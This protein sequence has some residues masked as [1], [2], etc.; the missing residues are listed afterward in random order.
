[1]LPCSM[2]KKNTWLSMPVVL[3]VSSIVIKS[4]KTR[5]V[6]IVRKEEKSAHVARSLWSRV[7]S[8][9]SISLLASLKMEIVNP[10]HIFTVTPTG[11][12]F[13]CATAVCCTL[14][15][16]VSLRST[17][18]SR[19][20]SAAADLEQRNDEPKMTATPPILQQESLCHAVLCSGGE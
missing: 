2:N 1:M 9:S 17:Y 16:V 11:A 18:S 14:H 6:L 13:S 15:I 4:K 20:F 3:K 8:Y 10:T 19:H 7:S 12:C 5:C